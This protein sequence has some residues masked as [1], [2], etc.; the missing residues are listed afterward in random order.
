MKPFSDKEGNGRSTDMYQLF[1]STPFIWNSFQYEISHIFNLTS[2]AH[3]EAKVR[4]NKKLEKAEF[5]FYSVSWKIL[6]LDL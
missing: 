5:V 4:G 6:L 1:L 2:V 3:Q